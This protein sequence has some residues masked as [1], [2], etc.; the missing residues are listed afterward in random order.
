[1]VTVLPI[2]D[3]QSLEKGVPD[4]SKKQMSMLCCVASSMALEV[5]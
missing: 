4:L 2:R 3:C 5:K 1:M